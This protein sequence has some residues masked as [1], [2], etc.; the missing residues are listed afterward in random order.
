MSS[1]SISSFNVSNGAAPSVSRVN[2]F[3]QTLTVGVPLMVDLRPF[4]YQNVVGQV[5]G[6]FLDNSANSTALSVVTGA[7]QP[8]VVPPQ[9]Q[10]VM[11]LYLGENATLT[12]T[13]AGTVTVILLNFPTPAAVW[14]AQGNAIP[15]SGGKVIVS[16]PA[17]EALING[18]ALSVTRTALTSGDATV[19]LRTGI[20]YS[21]TLTASGSTTIIT[22]SPSCFLTAADLW[23]S[24]ASTMATAGILTVTLA[25]ANQ[26]TIATRSVYVPATAANGAP[27]PILQL[28]DVQLLGALN[29]DNLTLSLSGALSAGGVEYTIVGGTTG[30]A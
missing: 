25:F 27:T 2:A 1:I 23:L 7:G 20:A 8:L 29:G 18:G 30:T 10:A 22:G 12:L 3:T 17:L 15:V 5:Q 24:P 13:G 16:D 28:R 4:R 6:A 26:G 21:G 11:P 14:S 19:H 9:S